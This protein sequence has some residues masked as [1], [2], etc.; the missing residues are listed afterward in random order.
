VED[1][2]TGKASPGLGCVT[3]ET[4]AVARTMPAE[5]SP[6]AGTGIGAGETGA[7]SEPGIPGCEGIAADP[8]AAGDTGIPGD[9]GMAAGDPG[10]DPYADPGDP[11][12]AAGDPG[13]PGDPGIAD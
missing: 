9:P 12:M 5:G 11:G 3:P 2:A 10:A 7:P 13:A 6:A 1:L 4:R 8:A